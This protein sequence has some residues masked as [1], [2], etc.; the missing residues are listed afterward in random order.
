MQ[1]QRQC[2]RNQCKEPENAGVEFE[3][4]KRRSTWRKKMAVEQDVGR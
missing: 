2:I 1:R 3:K 4:E